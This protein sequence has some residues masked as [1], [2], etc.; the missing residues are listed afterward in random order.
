[1]RK[2]VGLVETLVALAIF[3]LVLG[4]LVPAFIHYLDT[5]SRTELRTQAVTIAQQ[6]LEDL[7]VQDPA[8][9]PNNGTEQRTVSYQGRSFRITIRYCR[10]PSLCTSTARQITVEVAYRNR[11]IYA[12]ETVYTKLR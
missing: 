8:T 6:V 3:T 12:A 10:D 4:A 9:L 2:G 1:M 5:N 7:R 11:R